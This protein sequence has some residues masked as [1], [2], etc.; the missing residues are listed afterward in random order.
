MLGLWSLLLC[1][2]PHALHKHMCMLEFS[3]TNTAAHLAPQHTWLV[4][5]KCAHISRVIS[6]QEEGG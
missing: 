5:Q 4:G 6:L 1:N 3:I 2:T